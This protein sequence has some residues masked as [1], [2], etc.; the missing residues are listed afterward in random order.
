[1][2]YWFRVIGL[3]VLLGTTVVSHG[4]KKFSRYQPTGK[5]YV[6]EVGDTLHFLEGALGGQ[7]VHVYSLFG[8]APPVRA[9]FQ[10]N[11]SALLIDHFRRKKDEGVLKTYAVCKVPNVK[12]VVVY[13]DVDSALLAE[14]IKINKE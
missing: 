9:P 13:T 1:M 7:F 10:G 6:L 14:E 8:K 12:N 4:Q 11:G 3:V 5:D 2:S